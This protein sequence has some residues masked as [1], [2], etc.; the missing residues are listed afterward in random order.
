[1]GYK[2][3]LQVIALLL[4]FATRKVKVK[5][6]DDSKYIVAATYVTSIVWAVLIFSTYTLKQFV[7]GFAAL[8]CTGIFIGTTFIL[9]LIFMPKVGEGGDI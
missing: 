8:F 7:N 3:A 5:G 4:A 9:G 6:L 2:M 1:M